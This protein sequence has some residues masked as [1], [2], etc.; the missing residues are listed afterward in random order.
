MKLAQSRAH[1]DPLNLI[2]QTINTQASHAL[3][4]TQAMSSMVR[5]LTRVSGD[6]VVANQRIHPGHA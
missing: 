1:T 6:R 2:E 3:R 5:R 4:M